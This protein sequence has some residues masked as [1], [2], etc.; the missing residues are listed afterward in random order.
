V[1]YVQNDG[2]DAPRSSRW[3]PTPEE[4]QGSRDPFPIGMVTAVLAVARAL[5]VWLRR[6]VSCRR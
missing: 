4:Q 3:T 6:V 2:G 5:A 1:V